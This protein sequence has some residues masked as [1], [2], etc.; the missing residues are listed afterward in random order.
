VPSVFPGMDPYLEDAK[1]WPTFHQ[2]FI[3][4]LS[5]ALQPALSDKY[6]LR[7]GNRHYDIEQ[8]LFTSILKEQMQEPFLEI[9][10]KSSSDKLV[11]LIELI[12]P[13]NRTHP[14]G[15]RR[16]ELRRAEARMEGAHF[17]ELD[18]VL[19][20][21]TCLEAELTSLNESQYVCC[22]TRAARPIKHELYGTLLTKRL[23]RIRLPM[24]ADE[25][26]LVLD[27]QALVN[28]VYDRCFDRQ[29]DYN[30]DPHVPLSDADRHWMD[31]LLRNENLR[32]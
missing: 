21:Q 19:Q 32:K 7:L 31:Q 30:V 16:Y 14:E 27:V 29:I 6:R 18:L 26:D 15:K 4:A 5:D 23:P 8:V 1:R 11:T 20:G 25:R 13:T 12:S 17:V 10:Q 2:Q 24:Q 3:S 9:R 22:V 28:R